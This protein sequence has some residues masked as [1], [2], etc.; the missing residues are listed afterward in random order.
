MATSTTHT[1]IEQKMPHRDRQESIATD[2]SPYRVVTELNRTPYTH[3]VNWGILADE[4]GMGDCER[5]PRCGYKEP[6]VVI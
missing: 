6:E 5:T 1:Q 4:E 2:V 3:P